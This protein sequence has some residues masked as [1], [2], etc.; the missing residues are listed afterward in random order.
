MIIFSEGRERHKIENG[1]ES[2]RE[3]ERGGGGRKRREARGVE[4]VTVFVVER[5]IYNRGKRDGR[6]C[7]YVCVCRIY[8]YI[9]IYIL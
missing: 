3:R 8:I 6:V 1:R 4:I 7:M 2:E 5:N 9:Y